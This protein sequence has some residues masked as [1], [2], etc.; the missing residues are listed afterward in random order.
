MGQVGGKG[1]RG[2]RCEDWWRVTVCVHLKVVKLPI[3]HGSVIVH[4]KD[5]HGEVDTHRHRLCD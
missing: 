3:I 5:L 2:D 1:G 4:V